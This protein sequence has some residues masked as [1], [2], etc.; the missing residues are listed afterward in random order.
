[1]FILRE[2]PFSFQVYFS[3]SDKFK[4]RCSEVV[5]F[6]QFLESFY[7]V[8]CS[9]NFQIKFNFRSYHIAIYST[10]GAH[11]L[12]FARATGPAPMGYPTEP[13][14][15]PWSAEKVEARPPSNVSL[16]CISAR[17]FPIVILVFQRHPISSFYLFL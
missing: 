9:D 10:L 2:K 7:F 4:D 5:L 12:R 16:L 15:T 3:V 8:H 13:T 17:K 6:H 11:R 14:F 1:M